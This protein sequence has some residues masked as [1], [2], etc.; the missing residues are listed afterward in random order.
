MS[1]R[2]KERKKRYEGSIHK[3]KSY[4]YVEILEY[5]NVNRVVIKFIDTGNIAERTLRLILCGSIAD[6]GRSNT[7]GVGICDSNSRVDGVKTREYVIW[8]N[9]LR[10]CYSE[11][12][13]DRDITYRD[14]SVSESFKRFSYFKDWCNSQIGFEQCGWHLDKDILIKG[15]KEYSENSCCFVP[16]Q[17]NNLFTLRNRFRGALPL[18][19]EWSGRLGK[20]ISS[21][22]K[23]GK[24]V[25][26]GVFDKKEDA[27]LAYKE[28]KEGY[29]KNVADEFRDRLDPRV[30]EALLKW[31]CSIDD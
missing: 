17:I 12:E 15:N 16:R 4:G 30:Y 29:V 9:M 22:V 2:L 7:V 6:K 1:E 28:A 24:R 31:T 27:F 20:Y 14:C 25:H 5:I 11:V 21:I 13:N 3:S 8:S 19:V 26:L 10:R 18:G 23:F